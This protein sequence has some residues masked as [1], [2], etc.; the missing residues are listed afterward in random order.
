MLLGLGQLCLEYPTSISDPYIEEGI[1]YGPNEFF[2][3]T[4]S[5]VRDMHRVVLDARLVNFHPR[6]VSFCSRR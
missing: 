1:P 5:I 6:P 4:P 3:V 2:R